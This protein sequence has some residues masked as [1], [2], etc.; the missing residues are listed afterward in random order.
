MYPGLSQTYSKALSNNRIIFITGRS[1]EES[2]NIFRRR[3]QNAILL[4]EVGHAFK[5]MCF[6]MSIARPSYIERQIDIQ[7]AC[8]TI[9]LNLRLIPYLLRYV[10][11]DIIDLLTIK[12]VC[13]YF[14]NSLDQDQARRYVGPDLGPN[15][16]TLCWYS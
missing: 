7:L 16:L 13:S 14:A 4:A 6:L 8:A 11:E 10:L 12:V 3:Q 2:E 9:T 5:L 1:N 15:C